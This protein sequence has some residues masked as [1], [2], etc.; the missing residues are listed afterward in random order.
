LR[1]NAKPGG[2]YELR[3]D[4]TIV[5]YPDRYSDKHGQQMWADVLEL[6]NQYQQQK[7]VVEVVRA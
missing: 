5:R 2:L 3:T 7:K 4:A 1:L 6:L